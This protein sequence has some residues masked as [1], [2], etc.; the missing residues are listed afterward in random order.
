MSDQVLTA[1][2]LIDGAVIYL[3]EGGGWTK[4]LDAACVAADER[5]AA[6]LLEIGEAAVASQAVIAPYLIEVRSE[7]GRR[8]PVRNKEIIRADGPTVRCAAD[9]KPEGVLRHVPL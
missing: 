2:R 4:R 3:A 9:E 7:G 5:T 1:N 6:R 8:R